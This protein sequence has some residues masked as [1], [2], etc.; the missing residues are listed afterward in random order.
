MTHTDCWGTREAIKKSMGGLY[1]ART[2]SSHN[3]VLITPP[4]RAGLIGLKAWG[5]IEEMVELEVFLH[6]QVN[7]LEAAL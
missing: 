6:L 3:L 7:A 5:H 1:G 2:P 4:A